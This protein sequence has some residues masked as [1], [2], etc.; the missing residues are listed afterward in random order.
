MTAAA[1]VSGVE[2][3]EA[4]RSIN[5]SFERLA[6]AARRAGRSAAAVF[7]AE[8]QPAAWSVFREVL[9]SGRVQPHSLAASLSM[10]RS[11][12]SRHLKELRE[13][14]LIEAERDEQDARSTWV[15]AEP[16]A[17]ERAEA[18]LS[19]RRAALQQRLGTWDPADLDRFAVLLDRFADPDWL[20]EV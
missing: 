16:A 2:T 14:G 15:R 7:D 5:E 11:A 3:G 20:R 13:R 19:A 6:T 17:A 4:I 1:T 10:D 9:R 8:L 12:V 18:V